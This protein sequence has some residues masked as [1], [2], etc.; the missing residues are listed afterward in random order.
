MLTNEIL[1]ILSNNTAII[2]KKFYNKLNEKPSV[3]DHQGYVIII[4]NKDT[5]HIKFLR[6]E[7]EPLVRAQEL[8][9]K[10]EFYYETIHNKKCERLLNFLFDYS[11]KN[12]DNKKWFEINR[13][14]NLA[15]VVETISKMDMS[16]NNIKI[17]EKLS[18]IK[19]DPR[20]DIDDYSDPELEK[21]I[22]KLIISGL[23]KLIEDEIISGSCNLEF[24]EFDKDEKQLYHYMSNNIYIIMTNK[25]FL[26]FENKIKLS[27]MYL[28]NVKTINHI[29]G[30]LF[31]FDKIEII[32]KNNKSDTFGIYKKSI[33]VEFIRLLNSYCLL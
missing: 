25:R 26:K 2:Q 19:I 5:K 3:C 1:N 23:Q 28:N 9:V 10:L 24:F 14:I 29:S 12:I 22:G 13:F 27:E 6:T 31:H 20:D 17:P 16:P 7:K 18:Y 21:L 8:N 15:R 4:K 11:S 32:D 33:C 30:G